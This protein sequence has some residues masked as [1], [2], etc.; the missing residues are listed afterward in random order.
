MRGCKAGEQLL[1]GTFGDTV[2]V[3]SLVLSQV[4]AGSIPALRA[5]ER[6]PGSREDPSCG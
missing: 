3:C 4:R 6:L 1:P 2:L 5:I